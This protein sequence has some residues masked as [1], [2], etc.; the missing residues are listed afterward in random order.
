[1]A[2]DGSFGNG[3]RNATKSWQSARGLSADALV[4]ELTWTRALLSDPSGNL[5]YGDVNPQVEIW[6]SIIGATPDKSFGPGT[7]STTQEV[8]RFLGV[9][10]DG[11]VGQGTVDALRNWW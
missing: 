1:M 8:Q 4:G 7:K 6:Q 5:A 11:S 10:D 2:V 3:T 9:G